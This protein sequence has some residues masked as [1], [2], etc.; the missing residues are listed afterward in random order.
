MSA[1]IVKA[2]RDEVV[3]AKLA[4]VAEGHRRAGRV[5][6][7]HVGEHFA[8]VLGLSLTSSC[9]ISVLLTLNPSCAHMFG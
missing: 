8:V 3:H 2:E 1:G 4:H 7:F 5:L 9:A 6:R